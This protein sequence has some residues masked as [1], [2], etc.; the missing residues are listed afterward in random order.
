MRSCGW[1]LAGV[2]LS[3]LFPG[4]QIQAEE[5]QFEPAGIL[6]T[7]KREPATTMTIDWHT[8]PG[9]HETRPASILYR[10]A[11][12]DDEWRDI[13]GRMHPFP[14]TSRTVNRVELTGLEPDTLYSF[15]IGPAPERRFPFT[16]SRTY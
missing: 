2:L 5:E 16:E 6:L 12:T 11:G 15:R 8:K 1:I 10:K 14:Y 7:W 3:G 4:V 9:D 13:P